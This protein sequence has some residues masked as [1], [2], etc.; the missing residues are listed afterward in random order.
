MKFIFIKYF[1]SYETR[2]LQFSALAG[3]LNLLTCYFRI[4]NFDLFDKIIHA[5]YL[6]S[7]DST[8]TSMIRGCSRI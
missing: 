1:L 6:L 7:T 2:K 8:R 5:D 3:T 4:V